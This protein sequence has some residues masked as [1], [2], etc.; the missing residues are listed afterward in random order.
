MRCVSAEGPAFN[1]FARSGTYFGRKLMLVDCN[2]RERTPS[3]Y[4][5][6]IT[7]MSTS[8]IFTKRFHYLFTWPP[9]RPSID[10]SISLLCP[11]GLVRPAGSQM[12][13]SSSRMVLDEFGCR[14][15]QLI[16]QE[17]SNSVCP[18]PRPT[19]SKGNC[20]KWTKLRR[21]IQHCHPTVTFAS[22]YLI[23]RISNLF[24]GAF[25][26]TT[27]IWRRMKG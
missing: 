14:E 25:S 27:T 15:T 6:V 19:G 8:S 22:S 20:W 7:N 1:L 10:L 21:R 12:L 9:A 11:G 24:K 4:A 13:R 3:S 18:L 16:A 2:L 23:L 17:W 26:V 5:K